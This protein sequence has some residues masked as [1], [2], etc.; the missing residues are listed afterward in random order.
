MAAALKNPHNE[1]VALDIKAELSL[2]RILT[3]IHRD[4]QSFLDQLSWECDST[5]AVPGSLSPQAALA[6]AGLCQP[7]ARARAQR[8]L[9]AGAE[10]PLP[11]LCLESC[12][13]SRTVISGHWGGPCATTTSLLWGVPFQGCSLQVCLPT[14]GNG[15]DTPGV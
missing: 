6:A 13:T 11:V 14:Q 10:Q 9:W 4:I 1:T 12:A 3:A 8:G 7:G 5:D 15:V 2:G